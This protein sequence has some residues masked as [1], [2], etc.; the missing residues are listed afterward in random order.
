MAGMYSHVCGKDFK[1]TLE[2]FE[3]VM[4][5][6]PS[7]KYVCMYVRLYLMYLMYVRMYGIYGMHV[8]LYVCMYVCIMY[9]C[10]YL[11]MH[12]YFVVQSACMFQR[13]FSIDISCI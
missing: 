9:V 12:E 13:G 3:S 11:Y 2:S 7:T 4:N 10:M 6:G 5:A 1:M 8:C